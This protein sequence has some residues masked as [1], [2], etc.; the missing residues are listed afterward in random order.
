MSKLESL[1]WYASVKSAPD[2]VVPAEFEPV[3]ADRKKKMNCALFA[4]VAVLMQ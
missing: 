1:V 4:S 2:T 3:Q